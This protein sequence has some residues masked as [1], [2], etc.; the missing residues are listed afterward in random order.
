MVRRLLHIARVARDPTG[1]TAVEFA[2]VAPVLLL[3]LVGMAKFGLTLNN[4]IELT[5]GVQTGARALALS[6]GGSTPYTGAVDAIKSAVPNLTEAELSITTSIN[7][8]ACS[9]D[10]SCSTALAG[11]TGDRVTVTASYPCNLVVMGHDF[12]PRCELSSQSSEMIE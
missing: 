6:R 12:A 5:S 3:L 10:S 1:A 8:T 11:A 9:S 4:Y 7:D 2:L